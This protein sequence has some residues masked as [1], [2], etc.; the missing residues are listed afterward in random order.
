MEIQNKA[1]SRQGR[2]GSSE[3]KIQNKE[4]HRVVSTAIIYKRWQ[5]F[6]FKKESS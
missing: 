3:S 4:L 2:D 6:D 5:I 1:Y